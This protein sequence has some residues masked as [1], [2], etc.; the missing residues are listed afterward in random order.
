MEYSAFTYYYH[1]YYR[2]LLHNADKYLHACVF[3]HLCMYV[4]KHI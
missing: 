2:S 3:A 4:Y 1:Y